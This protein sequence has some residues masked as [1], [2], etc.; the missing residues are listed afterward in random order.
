MHYYDFNPFTEAQALH[1]AERVL[2]LLKTKRFFLH[3]AGER[4]IY[5]EE[6]YTLQPDVFAEALKLNASHVEAHREARH[7]ALN[8]IQQF[9]VDYGIV[10]PKVPRGGNVVDYSRY[11]GGFEI[12]RV[13]PLAAFASFV[14]RSLDDLIKQLFDRAMNG[15]TRD[16]VAPKT[17][18]TYLGNAQKLALIIW[19]QLQAIDASN[20]DNNRCLVL[21]QSRINMGGCNDKGD[22]ADSRVWDMQDFP[23][24]VGYL[25]YQYSN[26]RRIVQHNYIVCSTSRQSHV[27]FE[28]WTKSS[29]S[30]ERPR[31]SYSASEGYSN[32]VMFASVL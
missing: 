18:R 20:T 15:K 19:K 16:D 13:Y 30:G 28:H 32:S 24:A 31:I 25:L 5:R 3:N 29:D 7:Q 12:C 10:A 9:E 26:M 21:L 11:S 6:D 14:P 2:F 17:R 4:T 27:R 8:A 23:H 1:A 22:F